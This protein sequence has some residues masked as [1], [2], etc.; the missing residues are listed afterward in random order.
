MK[1]FGDQNLI[2]LSTLEQTL[3]TDVDD[4][5]NQVEGRKVVELLSSFFTSNPGMLRLLKFDCC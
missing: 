3:S 5:G 4:D 1:E 2:E